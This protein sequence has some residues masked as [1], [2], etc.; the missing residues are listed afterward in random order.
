MSKC[1]YKETFEYFRRFNPD[2][3]QGTVLDYGSNYGTF[4]DSSRGQFPEENYT[5]ID[6]DTDAL[7]EGL[8]RFPKAKFIWY[9]GYNPVYNPDGTE[10]T[11]DFVQQYDTIISYS[12][13]THTSQEDMC[14]KIEWLYSCLNPGGTILATWLDVD[15]KVSTDFFYKKRI[16]DYGSCDLIETSDYTYLLD[17]RCS[18]TMESNIK[19]LLTFY[20][21]E[22]LQNLLKDYQPLLVDA[23]PDIPSCFQSCIIIKK[24]NHSQ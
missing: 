6:V 1:D 9:N 13:F 21:K 18:K 15:S 19:F 20:K 8:N 23:F 7:D 22:Y 24:R 5:G 3:I 2:I 10:E 12:V 17:N 16:R 11:C 14:N 4:L